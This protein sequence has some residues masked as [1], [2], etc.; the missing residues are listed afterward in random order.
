M[1]SP[2]GSESGSLDHGVSRWVWLL[3]VHVKLAPLSDT[4]NPQ[5]GVLLRIAP[6]VLVVFFVYLTVGMPLAAIPLQ[7]HDGLGF[8]TLTIGVVVGAQSLATLVTRQF[9]GSLSDRR[10]PKTAVMLGG[11]VS[12]TVLVP[13]PVTVM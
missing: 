9:A 3:S 7:V 12:V 2:E 5:R 8:D 11:V 6:F 10:G 1:A 4:T 13:V